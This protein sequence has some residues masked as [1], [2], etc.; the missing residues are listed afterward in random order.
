[1]AT[2][3]DVAASLPTRMKEHKSGLLMT[4]GEPKGARD[5]PSEADS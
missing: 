4:A 5:E 3:Y 1:M 2:Y